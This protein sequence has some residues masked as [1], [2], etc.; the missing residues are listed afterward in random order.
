[1]RLAKLR[2]YFETSPAL[3]LL[4]SPHAAYIVDFLERQFKDSGEIKIAIPHSELLSDLKAYLEDVQESNPDVLRGKA[5]TYLSDWCSSDTR[6]LKR[7][8]ESGR[9]DPLYQLTPH[10]EEVLGFLDQVLDKELGFVGTE[11]RLRQVIQMLHDLVI[12]SSDDPQ[13]RL[14]DLREQRE[15]LDAEIAA[16]EEVGAVERLRPTRIREQFADAVKLLKQLQSDF[17]AVEENFKTI[18]LQVQRRQSQGRDSRGGILKFALDEEDDVLR[19][20]DQGISFQEFVRFILS[21]AEQEHLREVIS[22][23]H[24]IEELVDQADGLEAVRRMVPRLMAEANKVMKTNQR[25]SATLRRLLD[26]QRAGQ[27]RRIAQLLRDIRAAAVACASD[28]PIDRV[29]MVVD[30]G[31][32][33]ASPL[34]RTFWSEPARFDEIDLTDHEIDNDRRLEAFRELA[35]MHRLD[36]RT[37]RYNISRV[38]ASRGSVQLSQLLAEHP[39]ESGVVEILGYLQIASDDGHL[40][41]PRST[42]E[43]ILPASNGRARPL[44]VT[45]PLVTFLIG[46]AEVARA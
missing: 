31:L 17:R 42:E 41:E 44:A 3:R 8:L 26:E 40:I 43:I 30:S 23:L 39:P 9:D 25:L 7:F 5:E 36:W 34:S 20:Q 45:V 28:P 18:T 11:S 37:M 38:V 46:T 10:T 13:V 27:R 14:A 32:R 4:R 21:P 12:G 33:I 1:M 19:K 2:T 29:G 35:A 15:K 24:Q 16:I 6:W 22:G